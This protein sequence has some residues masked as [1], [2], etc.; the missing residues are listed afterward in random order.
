MLV[1]PKLAGTLT[2]RA[3]GAALFL[4]GCSSSSPRDMNYDGTDVGP[5]YVPTDVAD[6]TIDGGTQSTA[7]DVASDVDGGGT[8]DSSMV[9]PTP[10]MPLMTL[11]ARQWLTHPSTRITRKTMGH[12]HDRTIC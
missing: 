3:A 9:L 11:M 5:G 10:L 8:V 2:T 12:W 6:T 7:K 1:P 4:T